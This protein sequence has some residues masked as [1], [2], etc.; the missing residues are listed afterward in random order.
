M[1]SNSS[2]NRIDLT[3]AHFKDRVGL[4]TRANR[5]SVVMNLPVGGFLT[6]EVSAASLP[7]SE[8]PA[9]PVAFRGR[10]LKLPGDRRYS[11]WNFTVYDSPQS[12]VGGE[13]CWAA[14]HRWSDRIN[15]HEPNLTNFHPDDSPYVAN[16]TIN[17]YD[18]NGQKILKTITL[19]NCWP[20]LVG[21]VELQ[22]GSMDTLVQFQCSV[23]YEYFTGA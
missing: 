14:L 5:Y 3:L 21:P 19:H 17:H 12:N 7:A 20:T 2:S 22:A 1:A 11:P 16:W 10:I 13:T 15:S 23:E 18:L 8:L 4:G 6:A 9:I